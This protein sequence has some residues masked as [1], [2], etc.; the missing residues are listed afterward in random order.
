M[1]RKRT[2][3]I[4]VGKKKVRIEESSEELMF[5]ERRILTGL[6]VST[7]YLRQIRRIWKPEFIES[8]SSRLVAGWCL[9]YYD[10]YEKAP[11][12]EIEYIF[13][14]KK[15]K[16]AP[17]IADGID[18][19]LVGLSDEF[20]RAGK[21]NVQYLVDQTKEYLRGQ[22]IDSLMEQVQS[23]LD[24][25]DLDKAKNLIVNFHDIT[26]DKGNAIDLGNREEI[27]SLLD[28]AFN[29]E[30]QQVFTYPKALGKF[31]NDLL[32]RG[33]FIGVMAPEKRGK[34]YF[35]LDA[36][37]RAVRQGCN[38]A[39]FQVGDMTDEQQIRRY[40]VRL[41]GKPDREKYL[42]VHY[43]PVLDCIKNQ[44]DDC[45]RKV[46]ECT[47]GPFSGD[48][49]NDV[50][51]KDYSELLEAREEA[52]GYKVCTNCKEFQLNH[53]GA[54]W[55]KK[56]VLNQTVG[57][58]EAKRVFLKHMVKR[59]RR[60]K[61]STHPSQTVTVE[62]LETILNSWEKD[63]G[64]VADLILI[65]YAD[66]LA[67]SIKGEVRHQ[68]ND[69]WMK[70]R[71]LSQKKHALVIAPTQTDADSYERDIITTKNYSEDKRKFGHVTAMLGLNQDKEGKEKRKKILRI[72]KVIVREDGFA[73]HDVVH[74]LQDLVCGKPIVTSYFA[75]KP[76]FEVKN[77]NDE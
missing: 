70:L 4:K 65:D 20:K 11:L 67:A 3:K 6:I 62:D 66:I 46:R 33:G 30:A 12:A 16:L 54:I 76:S 47:F 63:D 29:N 19:F 51:R 60:F 50:L 61:L 7:D 38:V 71:G 42:G 44:T 56:M 49:P 31:L 41:T 35:L 36:A 37:D 28:R 64:F 13:E 14:E 40:A 77:K 52:R 18:S 45:D 59:N 39:F 10:K 73:V 48:S 17:K 27:L 2:T 43:R 53:W 74:V 23:F 26:N 75:P 34:T 24:S 69:K 9:E 68:E 21:F 5:M 72:N 8:S 22:N 57:V 58:E 55:Y 1:E 32:V 15:K 25:G